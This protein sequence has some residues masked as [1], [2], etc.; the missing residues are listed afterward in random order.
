VS[1]STEST[2]TEAAADGLT[3]LDRAAHEAAAPAHER[4]RVSVRVT[5]IEPVS[6]FPK[7]DLHEL[8]AYRELAGILSWRDFRVRYKQ[9]FIG[10]AWAIIQPLMA[11]VVFTLVFGK[12]AKFPSNDLPYP[13]FLYSG[14]ILWTYFSGAIAR[15]SVSVSGSTGFITKVYFPRVL[16]PLSAVTSPI[17]DFLF[18]FVVLFGLMAYFAVWP[19]WTIALAP[20]FFVLAMLTAFGVGMWFAAVNVRYRDVPYAIPFLMQIW[21]FLSPIVY[22]SSGLPHK[23]QW[24]LSLNPLTGI[25]SGF[26]WA[27]IG[28]FPPTPA[29]F[30]ISAGAALVFLL[31]GL[32]FFR[33]SEAGFADTI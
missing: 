12:F 24:L 31:S 8:W 28:G 5:V 13:I 19:T 1:R 17:V 27:L 21:M 7:V 6:G 11:M 9:T 2:V 30:A 3:S 10:V 14:L 18:S 25:I 32:A 20:V 15:A 16:L 23:W 22:A 4:D 29:Q 26:R 33:R